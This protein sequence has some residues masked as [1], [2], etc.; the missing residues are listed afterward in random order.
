MCATRLDYTEEDEE[1]EGDYE[2]L[3]FTSTVLIQG[4]LTWVSSFDVFADFHSSG[5]RLV[6]LVV[7]RGDKGDRLRRS[8][9]H[10]I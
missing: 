5:R 3:S 8:S 1:T 10:A 2:I 7:G 6:V 9:P 4:W